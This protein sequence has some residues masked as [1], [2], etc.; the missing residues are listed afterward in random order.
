MP[1][2]TIPYT[3]T[4]GTAA[5]ASEVNANFVAVSSW[6]NNANIGTDSLGLFQARTVPFGSSP[7][8]AILRINQ[9]S[10]NPLLYM[11][12]AG[13]ECPIEIIQTGLLG[14]GKAVLRIQDSTTQTAATAAELLMELAANSTVPALLI[15][16]GGVE[17]LKLTKNSL[18]LFNDSTK[19][20]SDRIK[21]PVKTTAQRNAIVAPEEGSVIYNST[22]AQLNEKRNDTWAPVGPPV[23]SVQMF[24]GASAPEGWLLCDGS[25]LN[26][27]AN[28]KYAALFNVIVTTYGGTGPA[29]FKVP[30]LQGRVAIGCGMGSGLTNRFLGNTGGQQDLEE[31]SHE[32]GDLYAKIGNAGSSQVFFSIDRSV[33]TWT[34]NWYVSGGGGGT[35][36][37]F[38]SGTDIVGNTAGVN[39]SRTDKN[40]QPYLVLNYIIKY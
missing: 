37:S 33:A 2:L 21:L 18:N 15:K 4:A 19:V 14:A 8:N 32:G 28:P 17:S 9:T 3:F 7:T 34:S 36:S 38:S 1:A 22:T 35:G 6:A 13:T 25:T 23:G 5:K 39:Q 11:E 12:N 10:S 16:H 40:M 24:A 31:H 29:S 30:D 26:S 20:S 27:V